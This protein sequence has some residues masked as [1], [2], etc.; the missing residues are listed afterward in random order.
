[1][2]QAEDIAIRVLC[3]SEPAFKTNPAGRPPIRSAI[4]NQPVAEQFNTSKF[5]EISL[6][7]TAPPYNFDFR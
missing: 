2:H 1:L 5:F 6:T 7:M 4:A 3:V